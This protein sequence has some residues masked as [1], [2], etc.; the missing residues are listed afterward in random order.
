MS[1]QTRMLPRFLMAFGL[2]LAY[3]AVWAVVFLVWRDANEAV[4]VVGIL[5]A[6]VAL[7]AIF[8]PYL[9]FVANR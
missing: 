9:D 4:L 1:S 2:V 5:A 6:A 3:M 7:I 8:I